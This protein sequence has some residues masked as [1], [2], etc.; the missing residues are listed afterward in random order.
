MPFDVKSLKKLTG[1]F[2]TFAK[3]FTKILQEFPKLFGFFANFSEAG[4]KN[5][6]DAFTITK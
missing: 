6:K 2:G 3:N 1:D 4:A 5:T